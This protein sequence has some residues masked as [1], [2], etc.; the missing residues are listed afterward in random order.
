MFIA[1]ADWPGAL[2]VR[3]QKEKHWTES[4]LMK[5][6]LTA[7]RIT[8]DYIISKVTL[9]MLG[10]LCVT[11]FCVVRLFITSQPCQKHFICASRCSRTQFR[12][13]THSKCQRRITCISLSVTSR[14]HATDPPA[15][16]GVDIL[17]GPDIW[18]QE[19]PTPSP[20]L[21]RP[22][23]TALEASWEPPI[24]SHCPIRLLT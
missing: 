6:S 10:S 12:G 21:L 22:S 17:R 16:R 19:R 20:P 7:Q 3:G 15:P 9:I 18:E 4:S 5:F 14:P 23:P 1:G 11:T 24:C 8:I 13:E 2:E